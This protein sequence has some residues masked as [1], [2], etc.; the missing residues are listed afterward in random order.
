MS[1]L[2]KNQKTAEEKRQLKRK[3]ISGNSTDSWRHA[4]W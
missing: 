2:T 1:K 3:L 4:D